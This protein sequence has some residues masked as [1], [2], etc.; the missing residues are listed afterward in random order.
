MRSGEPSGRS[1]FSPPS[2]STT[3][4]PDRSATSS[5]G[6]A[7]AG[8]TLFLGILRSAQQLG[9]LHSSVDGERVFFEVAS[10]ITGATLDAQLRDD[11]TAF[12]RARAAV[13]E[14]MQTGLL[15]LR[16]GVR[17]A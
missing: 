3:H 4:G 11:A 6:S 15:R 1:F 10:L 14:F 12:D 5:S 16:S 13:L 7:S 9:Q 2:S 8:K 17:S